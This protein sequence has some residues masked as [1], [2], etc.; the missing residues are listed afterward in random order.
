MEGHAGLVSYDTAGTGFPQVYQV[1]PNL[2]PRGSLGDNEREHQKSKGGSRDE[3]QV[4]LYGGHVLKKKTFMHVFRRDRRRL[5]RP[6]HK[7]VPF[8]GPGSDER[9]GRAASFGISLDFSGPW[10]RETHVGNEIWHAT[11]RGGAR[12]WEPQTQI[13]SR[14]TVRKFRLLAR[15]GICESK[16]EL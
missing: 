3:L 12:A 8:Q 11:Q 16:S 1:S 7:P 4:K 13:H 5:A 2:R 15:P 6:T 10:S 14:R 9:Q